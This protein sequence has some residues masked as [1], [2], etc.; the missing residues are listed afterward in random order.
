MNT[1]T[2]P[3]IGILPTHLIEDL[4]D[5]FISSL[6]VKINSRYTYRRQIKCFLSWIF[7]KLDDLRSVTHEDIYQYKSHLIEKEK[8]AYTISGYLT[9]VRQFFSWL[10]ANKIFPNIAKSIKGLKKP[11]G[12]RKDC[13]TIE[14]IKQAL[15]SFDLETLEGVR[16][17]AIF[18]L[19]VRTG[20]RT[21]EIARATVGDISRKSNTAILS[22]QGKGR[23]SKDD[24]VILLEETLQ[25]IRTYLKKRGVQNL[26]SPLFT[27]L[28][29]RSYEEPLSPR[30]ISWIIKETFRSIDLD[31]LRI[32]AHSLRHTAI[33]L[34]IQNGASLAQ[35]QAMARHSDP[36]TTMVYFH[37]EERIRSAAERFIHF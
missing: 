10:E 36:K 20:L 15:A 18:N 24:F 28:S 14:Q 37:N 27:S 13:L 31:D 3:S 1:L 9:V 34:S 30:A 22:I 25:P 21:I 35:A 26:R 6:D 2:L 29:D 12:F 17:F 4:I 5:K 19:L 7:T 23:D 16:N 11:K 33:S 32:S 8:S